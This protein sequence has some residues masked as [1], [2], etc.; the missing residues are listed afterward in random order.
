[1]ALQSPH[2]PKTVLSQSAPE[3]EDEKDAP[4]CLLTTSL[5]IFTYL[6]SLFKNVNTSSQGSEEGER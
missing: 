5:T 6:K 1:L 2:N 3:E 4:H